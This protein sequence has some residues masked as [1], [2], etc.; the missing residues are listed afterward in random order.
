MA[1]RRWGWLWGPVLAALVLAIGLLPPTI[2]SGEGLLAAF[3]QPEY[4]RVYRPGVF[5]E[6]VERAVSVQ[7]RRVQD[8]RLADS[9]LRAARGASALRSADGLVTLVYERPLTRDSALVWLRA[10]SAELALYPMAT[11]PGLPLVVGLLTD[12][13]RGG[14]GR[15]RFMIF[16]TRVL[17]GAAAGRG[18]CVVAINLFSPRAKAAWWTLVARDGGG[19]P[20]GRFLDVCA[21]Y[22]RFGVPGTAV[23]KWVD[24]GPNWFWGGYDELGMRLQEARRPVRRDDLPTWVE[25]STPWTGAVPWLPIG[26]LDG[27]TRSCAQAAGLEVRPRR[28]H[29][30]VLPLHA[31]SEPRLPARAGVPRAIRGFLAFDAAARAGARG[32]VRGAGGKSRHVGLSAL[33][34]R[35]R[36]RRASRR[37][38]CR[39][40]GHRLG[41]HR[42][43]A[44]ARRRAAPEER[45]VASSARAQASARAARPA[46]PVPWGWPRLGYSSGTTNRTISR[47]RD[48]GLTEQKDLPPSN[49]FT[50]LTSASPMLG[51]SRKVIS[52]VW[53]A[54]NWKR[55]G[56]PCSR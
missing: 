38:A 44:R 16:P 26:C 17:T 30:D 11:T 41:S 46:R 21:L 33:V 54:V 28:A 37:R 39:A 32:G 8:V 20:V 24:R 52:S 45:A 27:A 14:R 49:R 36:D 50:A 40:G 56:R 34:R 10:A 29:L 18:A 47:S 12:S 25:Y 1:L 35:A 42:A 9:L 2:P 5:R 19:H 31:R 48:C 15:E 53:P 22:G 51:T 4:G 23:A 3:G 7:R 13:A 6:S 43:G 55:T